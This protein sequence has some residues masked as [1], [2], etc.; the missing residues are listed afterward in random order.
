VFID[1]DRGFHPWKIEVVELDGDGLPEIA[2][3]A[4]KKTRYDPIPR[5][6]LFVLDW[7]EDG[8]LFAKWLGSR[9]GLPLVDFAFARRPAPSS[10]AAS[11]TGS[12]VDR[13]FAIECFEGRHFALRE[14]EYVSFGF[15]HA[16]DW[17]LVENSADSIATVDS[18]RAQMAT[19]ISR[20][21]AR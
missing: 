5:N 18:L 21:N 17:A 14:Y 7:T 9:L 4:F 1:F 13:L 6:R 3:G 15:C 8:V 16:H 19:L 2:V 12:D 11:S 20:R 10:A